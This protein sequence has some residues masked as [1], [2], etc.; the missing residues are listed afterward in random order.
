MS[1]PVPG[2]EV[3]APSPAGAVGG[4]LLGPGDGAPD[5]G[6][7]GPAAPA[8]PASPG[9]PNVAEM[10]RNAPSAA[11]TTTTAAKVSFRWAD[12]RSIAAALLPAPQRAQPERARGLVAIAAV[13]RRA[14]SRFARPR[15]GGR[16]RPV[17]RGPRRGG[18]GQPARGRGRRAG[19]RHGPRRR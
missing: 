9:R 6:A 19:R 8:C 15:G 2:A 12:V 11:R 3:V 14:R 13:T 4:G 10:I 16:G 7:V 17:G 1:G 5:G 18:R